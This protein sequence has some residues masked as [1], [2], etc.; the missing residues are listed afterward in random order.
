MGRF[1]TFEVVHDLRFDIVLGQDFLG[2][3]NAYTVYTA[4]FHKAVGLEDES[5]LLSGDLVSRQAE[6]EA[7]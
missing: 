3:T 4:C 2:D 5:G 6:A 1:A 7:K